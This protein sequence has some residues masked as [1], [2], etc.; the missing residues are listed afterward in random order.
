MEIHQLRDIMV[1]MNHYSAGQCKEIHKED[2]HK[3]LAM[4]DTIW[5]LARRVT[6]FGWDR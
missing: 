3:G 1:I 5:M 4:M 6:A 2:I